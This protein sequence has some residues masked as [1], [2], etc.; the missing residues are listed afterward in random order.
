M[1]LVV[2]NFPLENFQQ[3]APL[4][5]NFSSGNF[6]LA[7]LCRNFSLEKFLFIEMADP[8][9]TV[10]TILFNL[11][12]GQTIAP[13]TATI[14]DVIRIHYEFVV[15]G[16]SVVGAQ[17]EVMLNNGDTV[18]SEG[19]IGS[20]RFGFIWKQASSG[21]LMFYNVVGAAGG[22]DVNPSTFLL[23]YDINPQLTSP[24]VPSYNESIF[25]FNQDLVPN[26]QTAVS[27][28]Y[29]DQDIIISNSLVN[30]ASSLYFVEFVLRYSFVGA[31]APVVVTA[32]PSQFTILEP[33]VTI[34]KTLTT[35]PP[36]LPGSTIQWDIFVAVPA[37]PFN[38]IAY[39]VSLDDDSLNLSG[40]FQSTS[41]VEVGTS[42]WN[43]QLVAP[44]RATIN[45]IP[46]GSTYQFTVTGVFYS[47]Q[48]SILSNFVNEASV[49]WNS[50]DPGDTIRNGSS[51]F[52]FGRSGYDGPGTPIRNVNYYKNIARST[53]SLAMISFEKVLFSGSDMLSIGDTVQYA[54][55]VTLPQGTYT[56]LNI[57]DTFTGM[58]PIGT[59]II[60]AASSS[61]GL[62]N[63]D[64]SGT[65]APVI[66]TTPSP[67][68]V[69]ISFPSIV[70]D[71]NTNNTFLVILSFTVVGNT[72]NEATLTYPGVSV[73]AQGPGITVPVP[74]PCTTPGM[75]VVTKEPCQCN[76]T[77]G[78][79]SV[80]FIHYEN[81]GCT[82]V[83]DVTIFDELPLFSRGPLN[84]YLGPL[85]IP[86]TTPGFVVADPL[87]PNEYS[88]FIASVAP[89]E[90][91]TL[92]LANRILQ[93]LPQNLT[94]L[95]N[96]LSFQYS[97]D[98]VPVPVSP[99][100]TYT[101]SLNAYFELLIVK[102]VVSLN[103][104]PGGSIT[105]EIDV[106]N[107]GN[108]QFNNENNYSIVDTFPVGTTPVPDPNWT[109]PFGN[110]IEIVTVGPI[111]A[112]SHITY[113]L[114]LNIDPAFTGDSIVNSVSILMGVDDILIDTSSVAVSLS[115]I[116][117]TGA[118][119]STG[120][121]ATGETGIGSTGSTGSTGMTGAGSTGS[122]G[123]TGSSG[124]TGMTGRTGMTGMTGGTG[125]SGSTG[126]TGGT[127][128]TGM[129]G[130]TGG[131]GRTGVGSTGRTGMTGGTG[132]SGSTG[133]TGMTGAGETGATGGSGSTGGTGVSGNTGMTGDGNTGQTGGSG[134]TGGTGVTGT[135]GMTGAGETGSTGGT[136]YTGGTGT[137]GVWV[138]SNDCSDNQM[139]Y[140]PPVRPNGDRCMRVR[141]NRNKS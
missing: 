20:G 100:V 41:I 86:P 129:T 132:S 31:I 51:T 65:I 64:F 122:T 116:G 101:V 50:Q 97:V 128:M 48:P 137:T 82:P 126:S 104:V 90:S 103:P 114:T 16:S 18:I 56:G 2:E 35:L 21:A 54:L 45:R 93:N 6:Q 55:V 39:D 123:M 138:D 81:T 139:S 124:S 25:I 3:L 69:N 91:G 77:V 135:T 11:T 59:T 96:F 99:V 133:S 70:V 29:F 66:S 22:F 140:L 121:G 125:S 111:P 38:T 60:T 119:G 87:L 74:V 12:T 98:N 52:T 73:T 85:E 44:L 46:I 68:T 58:T 7:P 40:L 14:G 42:D 19:G 115:S 76:L 27:T 57:L 23:T 30:I 5:R 95:A 4:C 120:I 141:V 43:I 61:N 134:S 106:Y 71:G 88:F 75:L 9:I 118:T 117:A 47:N 37:G 33:E 109:L 105:Y 84:A 94:Q 32:V 136:G 108:R 13:I 24:V 26:G 1:E 63:S 78:D 131:T 36:Y 10:G 53:I 92:V 130:M 79:L 62:L 110:T 17:P 102:R 34:T 67:S 72:T 127:G 49:M 112:H 80:W 83:T 107:I 89:G 113:N 15:T 8:S 28:L